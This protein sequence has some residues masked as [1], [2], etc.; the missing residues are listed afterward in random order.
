MGSAAAYH[1]ARRGLSVL[2]IEAFP[3]GHALGSSAGLTRVIRLA[4][5]E[6]ADYVPLIQRAWDLWEALQAEAGETLL[7]PTGGLYV[8][9]RDGE[10]F[11][12]SLAS[13]RQHGLEHEALDA[14]E[15]ER[16]F[17]MFRVDPSMAALW[18]RKA[19]MLFPERCIEAHLRGA[20]ARGATLRFTERVDDPAALPA[21]TVILTAGAWMGRLVRLPLWVERVPLFWFEP[22]SPEARWEGLPVWLVDTDAGMFY[23]FPYLADQG[24]K[25]ARHHSGARCDPD[26]ID[27]EIAEGE[28]EPARAFLRRHLPDAAHSDLRAAKVCMY[29]NTPDGHFVVDRAAPDVLYASACSGHGFK[30]ASVVGEILADLAID[31]ATRHPIGLFSA[32][33]LST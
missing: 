27:R 2:G 3:R 20:E 33:R 23:G 28:D 32:S 29:T 1:L 12:K 5:F 17:P 18:E 26:A 11:A 21:R 10:V 16:R 15:L 13:A 7:V 9:Q 31:G 22:R 14:L 4:Y 25:V 8:G 6:H 19:G 24:L 30:F